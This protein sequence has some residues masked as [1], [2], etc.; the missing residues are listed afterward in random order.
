M[1][2]STRAEDYLAMRRSLGFKLRGE[3]RMLADFATRLDYA[4]IT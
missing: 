2:M 1:S 4:V 3:G